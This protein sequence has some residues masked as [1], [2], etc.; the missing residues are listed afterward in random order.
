MNFIQR[1]YFLGQST[2]FA[3]ILSESLCFPGSDAVYVNPTSRLALI[4][5][6]TQW[7]DGGDLSYEWSIMSSEFDIITVS[8]Y[9]L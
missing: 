9:F 5:K 6:C 8:T 7:C 4:G 3:H 2:F 1:A